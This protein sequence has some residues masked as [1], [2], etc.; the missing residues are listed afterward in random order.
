MHRIGGYDQEA[1]APEPVVTLALYEVTPRSLV[2]RFAGPQLDR[3]ETAAGGMDDARVHRRGADRGAVGI[4]SFADDLSGLGLTRRAVESEALAVEAAEVEI[5]RA[6]A[7]VDIVHRRG[8][9]ES[10]RKREPLEENAYQ[11]DAY[12]PLRSRR[13]LL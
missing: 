3:H 10:C 2:A 12:P 11:Q 9:G 8:G 13:N 1:A 7:P 4:R 6:G 5:K